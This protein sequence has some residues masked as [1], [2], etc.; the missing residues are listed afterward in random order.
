MNPTWLGRVPYPLALEMQRL[1]RDA[2]VA[3]V[4]SDSLWLLEHEPVYTTGR[5][6][7]DLDPSTLNAPLFASERGGLTT[8]HGPGQ[9]VGYLIV[10]V[11]GR[12]GSVKGAIAAVEEGIIG[13]LHGVGLPATRLNG[14]PGVWVGRDKICAIGMH[15][16]RGVSM[17]GFA[18]NLHPDLR[19]FDH[20]SPCGITDGGVTSVEKLLGN[21]PS[22]E[23]AWRPV[24]EFVC[25]SLARGLTVRDGGLRS[26]GTLGT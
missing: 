21:S 22:L 25:D 19:W 5:R 8:W 14:F 9:L 11:G 23:D 4:A 18:L 10:D 26:E 7:V 12:G 1:R 3:H 13:W 17:H 15:F 20:I 2:V 24:G 6:V 16:R